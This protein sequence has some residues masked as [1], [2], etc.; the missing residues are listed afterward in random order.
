MNTENHYQETDLGNI[1]PNPRGEYRQEEPYEYLDLVVFEGGSYVCL[2]E[3]GTTITGISPES[4][5]TTQY[6]QVITI[7]GSLTP[8]YIAMHDRVVNLSEQVEADTEEVRTAEQNVSGMEMNVAQMQEQTR[9][10]AEAV[11][12]SKDSAAG[13]A[14]SA[15]ASRQ[16]VEESEQ[17]INAQVTG[18]DV[19]VSEKTEEAENEIEAARI[20]ANKAIIAQQEQSVNEVSRVVIEAV[21]TAQAAAQTA[22]EKACAAAAS[23]KNAAASEKAA[24]LSEENATKMAEQ[25]AADKEQ[26]AND[27]TAVENAKK[28]MAGSAAQIEKN[29]QGISELK[30]DLDELVYHKNEINEVWYIPSYG[31]G[32]PSKM[33]QHDKCNLSWTDKK[34]KGGTC[35]LA[36]DCGLEESKKYSIVIKNVSNDKKAAIQIIKSDSKTS[37]NNQ[38]K[39]LSYNFEPNEIK[40]FDFT[41]DD[42]KK[43]I[44][45]QSVDQKN[46]NVE[47]ELKMY[48]IQ[49]EY[50]M[51]DEFEK[52][53]ISASFDKAKQELDKLHS[54]QT[55]FTIN[56]KW[57]F[58]NSSKSDKNIPSIVKN[59]N[60]Y[61]LDAMGFDEN[62]NME[63]TMN[64][65]KGELK[66]GD[67]VYVVCKLKIDN[68]NEGQSIYV[69][70]PKNGGGNVTMNSND[71]G[72]VCVIKKYIIDDN[73]KS[74]PARIGFINCGGSMIHIYNFGYYVISK[75]LNSIEEQMLLAVNTQPF[76][77]DKPIYFD[78]S[79]CDFGFA[80]KELKEEIEDVK[81][82]LNTNILDTIKKSRWLYGKK[83]CGYGTSITE[84]GWKWTQENTGLQGSGFIQKLIDVFGIEFINKGVGGSAV[85]DLTTS[86]MSNDARLDALPKDADV[87]LVEGGIN[88]WLQCQSPTIGYRNG[89]IKIIDYFRTNTPDAVLIFWTP[90]FCLSGDGSPEIN[91]HTLRDF[92][93]VMIEVCKEKHVPCVDMYS[94]CGWDEINI[95]NYVNDESNFIHPNAK[96]GER[97]GS[98]LIDALI[99]YCP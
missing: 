23:E 62:T 73:T 82:S 49:Q 34:E 27:R 19:H 52:S 30:G 95:A 75:E 14:S 28:E 58:E 46:L 85:V 68:K 21:S 78:Q 6:W 72:Y 44:I 74:I 80:K 77:F 12:Q 54:L 88:D 2:A 47:I 43:Y 53:T 15:D 29:A 20:A 13:Y 92:A 8:E 3:N 40:R 9:K 10:S 41:I 22:T 57:S 56:N 61:T 96:G 51:I 16:A 81:A 37:W 48:I 24:K 31:N 64:D 67:I 42:S 87:Y 7:P 25:V 84:C 39:L 26:V 79:Y 18:F 55:L 63:F 11:E 65:I 60:E 66:I 98:L 36:L 90:H 1:A 69:L 93:D 45:L 50:P 76:R 71:D 83:V 35:G 70:P 94:L 17:N 32:N 89:L 5:K 38:A 33:Q 59:E 99:K 97:I 91:N 4:G 86:C